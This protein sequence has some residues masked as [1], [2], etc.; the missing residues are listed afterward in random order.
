M[1]FFS[2]CFHPAKA[3][4]TESIPSLSQESETTE[5]KTE[6]LETTPEEGTIEPSDSQP[7]ETDEELQI[8]ESDDETPLSTADEKTEQE[9]EEEFV[10]DSETEEETEAESSDRFEIP[11]EFVI[12]ESDRKGRETLK[13][14]GFPE[15]Y[16]EMTEAVDYA[17]KELL[18]LAEDEAYALTAASI[19]FF[20]DREGSFSVSTSN[21]YLMSCVIKKEAVGKIILDGKE[22]DGFLYAIS[23]Y[24]YVEPKRKIG[25]GYI[26][27]QANDGSGKSW[28]LKGSIQ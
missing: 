3:E 2:F 6:A 8:P 18:L 22:V 19:Y 27:I 17:E 25:N 12:Q 24:P 26:R 14:V 21:P 16:E 4:E 15:K 10:Q 7:E 13:S 11:A 20:S 5:G 9:S 28:K 1:M 23:I